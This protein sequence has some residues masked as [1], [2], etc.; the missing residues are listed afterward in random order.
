MLLNHLKIKI[1]SKKEQIMNKC[2][3]IIKSHI[4]YRTIYIIKN[5]NFIHYNNISHIIYLYYMK[6]NYILF[7]IYFSKN[8]FDFLKIV[9][10]KLFHL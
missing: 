5:N 8:K 10:L 6:F 7:I 2:N 4:L 3:I 1:Y 9:F